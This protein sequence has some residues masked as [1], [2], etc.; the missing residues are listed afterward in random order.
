MHEKERGQERRNKISIVILKRNKK[1]INKKINY[2]K[3]QTF[4]FF[5]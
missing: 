2:Q 1:Y 4:Y 5:F 3:K